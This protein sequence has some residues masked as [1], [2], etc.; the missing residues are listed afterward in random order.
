M[1]LVIS[2][3]ATL[4]TCV[5]TISKLQWREAGHVGEMSL[6]VRLKLILLWVQHQR[7]TIT[8]LLLLFH[9]GKANYLPDLKAH[10]LFC[11][12]LNVVY[13]KRCYMWF[14]THFMYFY[15]PF[16][17]ICRDEVGNW[18]MVPVMY[19]SQPEVNLNC[20]ATLSL[21]SWMSSASPHERERGRRWKVPVQTGA[22]SWTGVHC[23]RPQSIMCVLH[24]HCG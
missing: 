15:W 21:A 14:L 3:T 5:A 18:S 11:R 23:W 7:L 20:N 8:S 1:A 13:R 10:E 24:Q 6:S 22:M 4:L 2:P 19:E 16:E 9:Q 17:K 12:L